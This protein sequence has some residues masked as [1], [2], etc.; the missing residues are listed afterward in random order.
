MKTIWTISLLALMT[1]TMSTAAGPAWV[2]GGDGDDDAGSLPED[3]Q[4]TVGPGILITIS[5]TLA[6]PAGATGV[7]D[8][9]DMYL[10]RIDD[11]DN[12]SATTAFFPG[13][14]EFDS[15]LYLFSVNG[16][17]L[18][19]GLGILGNE[20]TGGPPLG[21]GPGLAMAGDPVGACCQLD[22]F[23]DITTEAACLSDGGEYLGDGT[24]CK[25]VECE[26]AFGACCYEEG[27]N[28][29]FYT[30]CV[31]F[32]GIFLGDG[33]SCDGDDCP[34]PEGSTMGNGATDGSGSMVT[35]PG[36]YLLAIT[37]TPREPAS[38]DPPTQAIFSFASPDEVSG[39]DGPG[40]GAP[41]NN[42]VEPI[43]GTALPGAPGNYTIYLG[44]VEAA[45]SDCPWDLDGDGYVTITD[46][47]DLVLYSWGPCPP[48]PDPCPA[49][50]D[51]DGTVG[52]SD[53]LEQIANMGPCPSDD[54]CPADFDDDNFVGESDLAQL[55]DHLGSCE[56]GNCPWDLNGNGYVG[57]GDLLILLI[58][59]GACP[60]LETPPS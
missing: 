56:P 18:T 53:V 14:T 21:L 57:I 22:G 7:D 42:W 43:P 46:V 30:Y 13:S 58:H 49:D 39:P 27:C 20:D 15:R 47:L 32:D 28:D 5:G 54:N 40:G 44:G 17:L 6:G 33:T 26:E 8:F 19:T 50:F 48:D 3:A 1:L 2:E 41:I 4:A 24:D 29:E 35:T 59:W 31:E 37:V 25:G 36:L 10:I 11:P 16:A 52:V 45:M 55:L 60:T 9:E 34:D 12:F 38:G 23:C 51:G